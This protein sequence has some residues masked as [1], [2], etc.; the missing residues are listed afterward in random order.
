MSSNLQINKHQNILPK[1]LYYKT[2]TVT[3]INS[4]SLKRT[5]NYSNNLIITQILTKILVKADILVLH[6]TLHP[7]KLLPTLITLIQ[8]PITLILLIKQPP[9]ALHLMWTHMPQ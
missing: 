8:T 1:M 6:P 9:L 5:L 4:E 3:T 2:Y 7:I